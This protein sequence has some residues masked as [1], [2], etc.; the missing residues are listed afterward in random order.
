MFI[1]REKLET[2][3]VEYILYMFHIEEVIRINKFSMNELEKS[4]ISKYHLPEEQLEE[5]RN[6]Y[7]GLIAQM[8]K[9]AIEEKGHLSF[10][11]ELIFQLNDLH[12][13]LLNS[14]EEERYLEHYQWASQYIKELKEKMSDPGLTEIEVCLD[15]LYAYMLLKMKGSPVSEETSE[16]MAVFTQMLRYLAKKYHQNPTGYKKSPVQKTL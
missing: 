13:Q 8:Q 12:I 10:V 14:P 4:I 16:A 3:V 2:N 15:G 9:D 6:W 5:V 11:K 1:A 7:R